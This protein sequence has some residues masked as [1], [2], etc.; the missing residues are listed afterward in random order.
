MSLAFGSELKSDDPALGPALVVA[1]AG[2]GLLVAHLLA[3]VTFSIWVHRAAKNLRGLGRRGLRFTPGWCVGWFFVP[4]AN[5]VKP[6]QAVQEVWRASGPEARD[7]Y[8][9]T[10]PT[11]PLFAL[12]WATWLIG[13]GLANASARI[14]DVATSGMVGAAGSI[15]T[16][17]AA[18][19]IILIMHRIAVRQEA[20]AR[21]S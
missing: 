9:A 2:L 11:S 16:A 5:L 8:W 15:L 1:A 7:D 3:A 12:W 19:A 4:F 14:D 10:A 17:V 21:C 18:V 20:S 6:L 13:N